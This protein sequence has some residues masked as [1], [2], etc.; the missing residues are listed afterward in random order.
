MLYLGKGLSYI[1]FSYSTSRSPD[2]YRPSL[3]MCSVLILNNRCFLILSG[4]AVLKTSSVPWRY[5]FRMQLQL[6]GKASATIDASTRER[7]TKLLAWSWHQILVKYFES[8]SWAIRQKGESQNECY[9][10]VKH[11][12]FS[13]KR[14]FLTPLSGDK[15]CSFFRKIW[16]ASF[17]YNTRFEIRS[18]ALLLTNYFQST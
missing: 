5:I 15:K 12:K 10:E 17:S 7:I 11:A 18:F 6:Q 9:K 2:V 14:L 1:F 8:N 4:K 13:E 3:T 16:H